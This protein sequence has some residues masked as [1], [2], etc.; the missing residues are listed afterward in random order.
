[1]TN[2]S[3]KTR[4]W[5]LDDYIPPIIGSPQPDKDLQAR[6]THKIH[7]FAIFMT[8]ISY[9]WFFMIPSNYSNHQSIAQLFSSQLCL[10]MNKIIIIHWFIS[11]NMGRCIQ[12]MLLKPTNHL[13]HITRHFLIWDHEKKAWESVFIGVIMIFGVI[14]SFK[15]NRGLA[16]VK[17]VANT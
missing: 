16:H 3:P 14:Y 11:Q 17:T 1:M 13:R 5:R 9:L 15:D 4:F 10:K 2:F 8:L 7:A 12:R 6:Q